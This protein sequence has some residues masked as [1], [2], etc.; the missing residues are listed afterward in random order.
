MFRISPGDASFRW[1]DEK[2]VGEALKRLA[3]YW[4]Y[5]PIG[6]TGSNTALAPVAP[7]WIDTVAFL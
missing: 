7:C 3:Q 5:F 1:H 6:T 4:L 2:G